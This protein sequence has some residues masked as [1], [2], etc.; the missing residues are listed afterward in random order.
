MGER[1]EFYFRFLSIPDFGNAIGIAE[2]RGFGV[3]CKPYSTW[4]METYSIGGNCPPPDP[5]NYFRD[6]FSEYSRFWENPDVA[7]GHR[8]L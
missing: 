1:V 5:V 4:P 6:A 8:L 2:Y 7:R 3:I